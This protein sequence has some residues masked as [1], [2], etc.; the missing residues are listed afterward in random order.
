MQNAIININYE[1]YPSYNAVA[2][3][4]LVIL[5]ILAMQAFILVMRR[6]FKKEVYP[7]GF[8]QV[9]LPMDFCSALCRYLIDF[10][11]KFGLLGL[12]LFMA[13]KSYENWNWF[14]AATNLDCANGNM[15]LIDYVINPYTLLYEKS[16]IYSVAHI[17][18]LA[19]VFAIDIIH[20]CYIYKNE[21][22]HYLVDSVHR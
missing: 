17:A 3:A 4:Q 21:L 13:W 22:Q 2:I 6:C 5:L 11:C 16:L 19:V 1:F 18:L 15:E 10:F 9:Y 14:K 12:A 7:V 8:K 20:F